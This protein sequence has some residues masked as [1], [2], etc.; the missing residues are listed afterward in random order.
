MKGFK[1]Y[2]IVH[3]E[4]EYCVAHENADGTVG[5]IV[6]GG[7]HET[8]EEAEAHLAAIGISAA[9]GAFED[10]VSRKISHLIHSG[11]DQDQAIAIAYSECGKQSTLHEVIVDMQAA[12]T[13][14]EQRQW[15]AVFHTVLTQTHD[16]D[17]AFLAAWGAIR[18]DRA[19]AGRA[20]ALRMVNGKPIVRGWG[21]KFST[22]EDPD[23]YG[24]HFSTLTHL[25]AEYYKDA[26]LWYEHGMDID[27][28]FM[29]IGRRYALQIFGFGVWAEHE[30]F[31][32]HPLYERTKREIEQG[33]LTYS[34]DSI[35]HYVDAGV[36]IANGEL[37]MWPLA[38]WSLTRSPAEPGLGPVTF[39]GM[40]AIILEVVEAPA[41][42]MPL[43]GGRAVFTLTACKSVYNPQ[44]DPTAETA[45][46]RPQAR[47]ARG[48]LSFAIHTLIRGEKMDPEY[49]AALAE[50]LGVDAT[51][52]A[53]LAALQEVISMLEG[54]EGENATESDLDGDALRAALQMDPDAPDSDVAVRMQELADL[55]I[56]PPDPDPEPAGARSFRYAALGRAARHAAD[57]ANHDM[58]YL[59]PDDEDDDNDDFDPEPPDR[60]RGTRSQTRSRRSRS[61]YTP[62]VMIRRGHKPGLIDA[63]KF[64]L[65]AKPP[66][67]DDRA[68]KAAV[69]AR[70]FQVDKAAKAQSSEDGPRGAYVLNREIATDILAPL[71]DALVLLQAGAFQWPMD[72]IDS[73]TIRKQVGVPGAYWAAE[74]T[75]VEGDDVEWSFATLNLKELR[76]PTTWPNRWLRNLAPG[77]ENMIRDEIVKAM[78]RK[79]EY[80]ALFGGG[81]TPADGKSTGQE[82]L[83]IRYTPNVT[84]RTLS[85]AATPGITDL[86]MA[87][88][89]LEDSNVEESETWSWVSSAR[90]FR[91]FEFMRDENGAPIL[92]DSWANGVRERTLVDYPYWKTNG[93]PINQG[94]ESNEST[95]FF[96]DWN[97]L[98]IGLGMDVELL[99][100]DQRYIDQNATFVMGVAYVDS[101]V[102]YPEAFHVTEGL[103]KGG[104][105]S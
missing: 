102:M 47:E 73:L 39:E 95:L 16:E 52:E 50:F 97:E 54:G 5:D 96:G 13:A 58:P 9:Q 15:M 89:S 87:V 66:N 35:A 28:G 6:D 7:C 3:R 22:P 38:G 91:T 20:V 74:L 75:E 61:L 79:M 30:L 19:V 31:T 83:G 71:T 44:I 10:C 94:A 84:I 100:S 46:N 70:L 105:T 24:E 43:D 85:P 27:Y 57:L 12:L 55:L 69:K 77:A 98:V 34:S 18:K 21:M 65:G 40:E 93:V 36:N 64:M 76:A 88:G 81:S 78:R 60:S 67:F 41:K 26:P 2:T 23:A 63:I 68:P 53:V 104:A 103:L 56:N 72:G 11:Y 82:P 32:D 45:V 48:T 99:V 86:E 17:K 59:V 42:R 90:T 4:D 33:L 62:T 1:K 37:R 80:S 25:L 14:D 8:R 101:A 49:L 29:P 92:R 51:P